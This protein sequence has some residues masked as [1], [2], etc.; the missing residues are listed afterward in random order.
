MARPKPPLATARSLALLCAISCYLFFATFAVTCAIEHLEGASH[1]V[2]H[3]ESFCD[4]AQNNS[5]TVTAASLP[6]STYL[7]SMTRL[8]L[9]R[10]AIIVAAEQIALAS[11]RAPPSRVA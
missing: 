6:S 11:P 2:T 5:S 4:W 3:V 7:L 9:P 1:D 8:D 10:A